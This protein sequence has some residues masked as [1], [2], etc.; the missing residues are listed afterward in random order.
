MDTAGLTVHR[1]ENPAGAWQMVLGRPDPRL[2]GIVAGTYLG[3]T[4]RAAG[5]VRRQ[6]VPKPGVPLILNLGPAFRVTSPADGGTK[7]RRY[8]SFLAG[9][10]ALP[11]LTESAAQNHCLQA[12]LTP[13]GAYRVLGLAMHTLTDRVVELEDLLGADCPLLLERLD[14]ANDWVGR[15]RLLDLMLLRR[16]ARHRAPGADVAHAVARLQASGGATRI[17]ELAAELG[18]SRR[19]LVERF[20]DQVGL[21]PKVLARVL[22][23]SRATAL[24]ARPGRPALAELAA[25][26]GYFDQP[27]FNREFRELAGRTPGEFIRELEAVPPLG[28]RHADESGVPPDEPAAIP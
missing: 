14:A 1:H 5:P 2:R 7:L 17:G 15:F 21:S 28:A 19:R 6:E 11:A 10:T 26:C 23:F 13:L 16:A 18:C 9:M 25:E 27:H 22:R 24:L 3:W 20:H 12:N 8:G 4:E